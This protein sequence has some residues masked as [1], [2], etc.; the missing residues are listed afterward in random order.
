MR[1]TQGDRNADHVARMIA[2]AEKQSSAD[3]P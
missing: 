3:Q 2:L 1:E